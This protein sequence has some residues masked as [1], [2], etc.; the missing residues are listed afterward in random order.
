MYLPK[1]RINHKAVNMKNKESQAS[2]EKIKNEPHKEE[3]VQK[4][5]NEKNIHQSQGAFFP[6]SR[7]ADK[8]ENNDEKKK[9]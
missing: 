4:G 2:K 7:S 8:N 1:V 6:D 9:P 3:P 5:Y